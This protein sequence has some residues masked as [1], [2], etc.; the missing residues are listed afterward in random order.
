MIIGKGSPQ[1]TLSAAQVLEL[2]GQAFESRN[3]NG[4]RILAIIPDN[5][6]S[7]PI[8]LMF[9]SVYQLLA[10]R[11]AQLDFLIAL[12]THPA[13]NEAGITQRLGATAEELRTKYPKA[14]IFNHAWND[15]QQLRLLGTISAE[16]VA[17]ISSGMMHEPVPVTINRMIFDYDLLMIIGPTFPHEVVGFSGGNKYLFPGIAGGEIIDM[18]HWLGALITS[19][20]IIGTKHTPVR[21]VVDRAAS[22]VPVER[23]CLSLVVK[24]KD[25]AGLYIGAPEEAWNAAADLSEKIHLI[26]KDRPFKKVLSCAPPMYNDLWVGGKCTY[27]LEPVVAEDGELIIYAPHIKEVSVSHGKEIQRIGYHVR[28]YFLKQMDKFKDVP[29]GI[30]AHSTHVKGVGTFENGVEKPRMNVI[31][32]T[33]IPEKVCRSINLGYCDPSSINVEE[34]QDREDEGILYVPKAGEILYRL[35]NDP[36]KLVK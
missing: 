19:P 6:R 12:G 27:K 30:M 31:L 4:K 10:A 32:A 35:K 17:E 21:K 5:T 36:F 15:P 28:D 24:G 16:E 2:C 18:F 26:Y 22:L 23:M 3:L 25:L 13:L 8:D 11:A 7:A 9:R 34:W 33:Q 14:R 29:G 1:E 20:V